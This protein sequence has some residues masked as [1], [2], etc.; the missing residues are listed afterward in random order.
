M[1]VREAR[2]LLKLTRKD[3][4][5]ELG[6]TVRSVERWESPNPKVRVRPMPIVQRVIAA[7]VAEMLPE[8]TDAADEAPVETGRALW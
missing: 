2:T 3:F 5:R 4:A 6:V 1:T 7:L 8:P